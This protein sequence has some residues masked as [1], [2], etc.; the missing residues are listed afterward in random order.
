MPSSQPPLCSNGCAGRSLRQAAP[1]TPPFQ[2]C[3][4]GCDEEGGGCVF[5]GSAA[6]CRCNLCL[7]KL[8]TIEE[9]GSCGCPAGRYA[10]T[11]D[12]CT[13]CPKGAWCS[14]GPYTAVSAPNMTACGPQLTTIGKRSTSIAACGELSGSAAGCCV[15]VRDSGPLAAR[16]HRCAHR[17]ALPMP[18][19]A[20]CSEHAGHLLLRGR[21][22]H[23]QRH[24]LPHRH[25][26]RRFAQAAGVRA[27]PPRLHHQHAHRPEQGQR[28][29]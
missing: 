24:R 26:Q 18:M 10:A 19:P 29:R 21:Q 8:V 1:T 6:G 28:L 27:L 13:D 9:D 15:A 14:G 25:L 3:P 12:D 16:L 22:R 23:P 7:N 4:A 5:E 17:T 11:P 20:T 2:C